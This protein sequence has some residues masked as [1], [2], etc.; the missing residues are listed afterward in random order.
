MI[1]PAI[2]AISA[3][4]PFVPS[5]SR[6]GAAI[7]AVDALFDL[8]P[9]R[10]GL[11]SKLDR[12]D[13]EELDSFLKMTAGLLRA[14]IVGIETLDIAGRPYESFISTRAAA[15]ELRG[16]PPLIDRRPIGSALN[17]RT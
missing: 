6:G 14:G 2:T 16:A 3:L 4:P 8:S 10:R 11:F 12:L 17:I 7:G 5:G 15:P 9:G 13:K 1:N